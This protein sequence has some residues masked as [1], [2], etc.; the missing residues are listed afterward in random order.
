MEIR[1]RQSPLLSHR[2]HL[3]SICYKSLSTNQMNSGSTY[4]Y[5][6][7]WYIQQVYIWNFYF[8]DPLPSKPFT[9]STW[10]KKRFTELSPSPTPSLLTWILLFSNKLWLT[11]QS[12]LQKDKFCQTAFLSILTCLLT[13]LCLA[14]WRWHWLWCDI[15]AC[16]HIQSGKKWTVIKYHSAPASRQP[17]MP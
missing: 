5:Y 13:R 10:G 8:Y 9:V 16:D 11:L 2:N 4:M 15:V 7:I 17:T 1:F 3:S 14:V 6:Y 12:N